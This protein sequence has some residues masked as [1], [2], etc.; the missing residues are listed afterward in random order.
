MRNQGG[1]LFLRD[2]TFFGVCEGLGEDLG[3]PSNLFRMAFALSFFFSPAGALGAYAALGLIVLLTRLL[4]PN[5]K[6]AAPTARAAAGPCS[7]ENEDIAEPEP[8]QIA[9]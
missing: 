8:M 7:A 3:I 1:N 4:V 5:P 2:D 6:R 9:A